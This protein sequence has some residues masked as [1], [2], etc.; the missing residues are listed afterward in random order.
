[1]G[2]VLCKGFALYAREG[3]NK[4]M[5]GN[6]IGNSFFCSSFVIDMPCTLSIFQ[7]YFYDTL[8]TIFK[9]Q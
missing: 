7:P 9:N 6:N 4:Q 3:V 1:M 8:K 5:V 2:I